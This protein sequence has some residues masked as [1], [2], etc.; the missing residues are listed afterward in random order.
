MAATFQPILA[1]LQWDFITSVTVA[2]IGGIGAVVVA[3]ITRKTS[4]KSPDAPA[5]VTPL[6][7]VPSVNKATLLP[8]RPPLLRR[9][10]PIP[11]THSEIAVHI[12]R[13]TPYQQST[14]EKDYIGSTVCWLG[15]LRSIYR[16]GDGIASIGIDCADDGSHVSCRAA[17]CDIDH[18]RL[19]D[20][21]ASVEVTG[22][23]ECVSS[24]Y[25]ELT[26]CLMRPANTPISTNSSQV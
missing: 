7:S 6:S 20:A 4:E 25:T 26:D 2:V 19:M 1:S 21:G 23:I 5:P 16:H 13:G 17:E 11:L 22:V 14:L 24:A 12:K 18:L 9:G 15:I 3:F 10:S 8:T